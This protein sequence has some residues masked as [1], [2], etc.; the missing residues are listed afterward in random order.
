MSSF[1]YI[2]GGALRGVGRGVVETGQQRAAAAAT[3]L[4]ERRANARAAAKAA[5]E[6]EQQNNAARLSEQQDS[7]RSNLKKD[8]TKAEYELRDVNDARGTER[9]T[10]SDI[11]VD[12]ARTKNDVALARVN[13]S[14]NLN[15]AQQKS[16]LELN[17]KLTENKQEVGDY[18]VTKDGSLV[19]YSK[20][21][22]ALGQTKAGIFDTKAEEPVGIG[23]GLPRSGQSPRQSAPP[24]REA[25]APAPRE[26]LSP[27]TPVKTLAPQDIANAVNLAVGK[28]SRGE[29]PWAGM[30]GV[31]IRAKIERDARAAGYKF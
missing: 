2:L 5:S 12:T 7:R 29:A 31:E 9:K 15:E 24:A 8:E 21:G 25:E 3:E 4:E 16:A 13:S 17:A 6:I 1:G 18:R 14:L 19:A 27:K 28:A 10:K 22:R 26:K 11:I 20:A 30:S 23:G